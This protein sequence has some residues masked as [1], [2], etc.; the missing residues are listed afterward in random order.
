MKLPPMNALRAFEA[1]SRLGSVSKAAEELCV[2][3][4][5]VSQQLRNLEDHLDRELFIR[6]P[7]SFTLSEEGETYASVVQQSLGDIAIASQE[8][9][10]AKTRRGLTISASP[11]FAQKW[12]MPNLEAFY[13]S[14]PDVP[15][16][17]DRTNKLV[18]FKNDG[19]DAAIRFTD[20][21]DGFNGLDSVLLFHPQVFA[22]ASP[23]Y[24][25]K[26]G[27]LKSLAE[28]GTHHLIDGTYKFKEGAAL[29]IKWQDVVPGLQVDAISQYEFFPD[30]DQAFNAALLGRGI[31]LV[32][33]NMMEE[34]IKAGKIEFA[35]PESIPARYKCFFVSPADA[36]P[37]GDLFA[38]RDWL[39]DAL[40]KYSA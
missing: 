29:H 33:H 22:V 13:E 2:S 4:G 24:I 34:E 17:I 5:A 26:H 1:V 37:N 6:K 8:V 39:V 21:D 7:N 36:G 27:M 16:A 20:S 28:P 40:K 23:A 15:I 10:R 31:A 35:N 18:T 12:L 38:F 32:P 9:A 19:I 25:A 30:I 11:G 14:F 3:Q